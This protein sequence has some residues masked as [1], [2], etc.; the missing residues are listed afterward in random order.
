MNSRLG[1]ELSPRT[2]RGVRRQGWGRTQTRVV[3]IAWDPENPA[4]A[5]RALKQ[6]L[7]PARRIAVALDLA[8]LFAKHVKLPPLPAIQR[9]NILRLEPERFF[10]VRAEDLVV[11]V[12]G[13]G[14]LV[15]AARATSLA[16]WI[17]ALEEL[18]SVDLIEPSPSALARALA[19]A[20]VEEAVVVFDARDDGV[21]VVEIRAGRPARV[22]RLFGD[23][24]AAAEALTTDG[25]SS[26][27]LTPWNDDRASALAAQ[28]GGE[29]PQPLPVVS[30]VPG[31]FLPAYG[32]ALAI[33]QRHDMAH[34][35]IPPELAARIGMRRRREVAVAGLACTAALVFALTSLD[36]WQ[37]RGLRAVERE[38]AALKQR[39]ETAL[40][41]YQRIEALGHEAQA[42]EQIGAAGSEPLGVLLAL[43]R[44]LPTGAYL[45]S[46]RFSS[47]AWQM[48]GYA[49]QA[50]QLAAALAAAPE[51][52]DVR[53]LSATNRVT[54]SD[55]TYE[56]ISLAFRFVPAP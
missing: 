23:L 32:A 20:A 24:D 53:F 9:Q 41:L 52:R 1:I 47:G 18:A 51:F 50:A 49:P 55:Q 48:D 45:R 56:S 43:S 28:L 8:L 7:G 19:R 5:V 36:A 6:E 14:N 33:G 39:G 2:L 3:E 38:L 22:R 13:D 29:P 10:P 15:F 4:E 54:M 40:A 37:R 35:L 42:L 46:L 34:T 25:A 21:G 17:A 44:R 27:Y 12:P 31:S 30:D 11:A 16:A 26:V